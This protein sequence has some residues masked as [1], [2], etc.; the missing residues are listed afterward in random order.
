M[1]LVA[2]VVRS[3]HDGAQAVSLEHVVALPHM[4]TMG[5]W[6]D[7]NAQGVEAPLEVV[8]VTIRAHV[9]GPGIRQP[10]ADVFTRPEP[11]GH[12]TLARE[13]GWRDYQQA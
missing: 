1:S 10:D 9:A 2:R 3:F 13:G 5:T 8:A 11:L 6:L 7:L 12:A 4:P